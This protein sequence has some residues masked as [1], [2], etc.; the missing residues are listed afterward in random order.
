MTRDKFYIPA[1]EEFKEAERKAKQ[2]YDMRARWTCIIIAVSAIII[3]VIIKL[4][5]I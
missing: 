4:A 2:K 1:W 3:A 5:G